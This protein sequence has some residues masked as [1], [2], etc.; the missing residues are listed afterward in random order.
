[1]REKETVERITLFDIKKIPRP[2][3]VTHIYNPTTQKAEVGD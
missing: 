2:S 1:V 3:V